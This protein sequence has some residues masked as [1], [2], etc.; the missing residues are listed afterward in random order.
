MALK[1][2]EKKVVVAE[3]NAVAAKALSVVGAENR[4]LTVTQMTDLR[5][6]ARKEG[7]Y[8]RI[9]KNTLARK[10][11]AGTSFEC[12][13]PA[14]KG[15]IVL[16]FSNDDPGAAARIVKAFAK[17]NDKLVTTLVS[18]GGQ[19]SSPIHS[20]AWLHCPRARRRCRSCWVCSRRRFQ[21]SLVRWLPPTRSWCGRWLLFLKPRRAERRRRRRIKPDSGRKPIFKLLE[22]IMA[23]TKDEILDA[24]SKMSVME[25]VELIADMEK[26]FNVTAAAPVA[27]AAAGGG[28][29]L[30][31]RRKRRPSSP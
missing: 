1:L 27:A 20:S 19:C 29:A 31:R 10:A 15:P 22:T 6:K 23:V 16:A 17:D 30:L 13:S 7:V 8:L 5:A 9:V 25:V 11:V 24:I 18:L 4:G 3:V 14:L 28:A 12:I 21:S 2:E 26:K